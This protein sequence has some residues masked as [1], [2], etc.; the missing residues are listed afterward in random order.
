MSAAAA[1]MLS[2]EALV[3]SADRDAADLTG[4]PALFPKRV[5]RWFALMWVAIFTISAAASSLD[6]RLQVLVNVVGIF[7]GGSLLM[8][9]TYRLDPRRALSLRMP[10]PM[11]WLAVLVGA[12]SGLVVGL[13]VARLASYVLPVP[14]ELIEQFG[15][16]LFPADVPV[17]QML[18]FIAVIPGIC[19]E[20][21]FRGLLL[22]GL[23]RRFRPVMLCLVVGAVFGLFHFALFR[24]ASTAFLGVVLAAV[25]V[26]TGSIFPA[27]LWHAMNNGI[28]V[29]ATM[30]IQ[31]D[32]VEAWWHPLVALVPFALSLWTMWRWRRYDVN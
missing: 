28:A 25:T 4:G 11:V 1:V 8:L 10:H 9:R 19:E 27:M 31:L 32:Y 3:T 15:Q 7:L 2:S 23:R 17:W 22:H 13:G 5:A 20:I 24:L 6:V 18:L 16:S 26:L 14:T 21:A 30:G 12:P 29:V